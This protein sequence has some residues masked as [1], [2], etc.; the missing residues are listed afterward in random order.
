MVSDGGRSGTVVRRALERVP[1]V[2]K[3]LGTQGLDI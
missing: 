2:Q 3:Y 1:D